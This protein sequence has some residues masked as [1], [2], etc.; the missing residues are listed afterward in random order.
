MRNGR[1]YHSCVEVDGM[2]YAPGGHQDGRWS[3]AEK[4][5]LIT[6]EWSDVAR[7][8]IRDVQAVNYKGHLYIVGGWSGKKVPNCASRKIFKLV[9]NTWEE[10]SSSGYDGPRQLSSPIILSKNQVYCD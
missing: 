2:M 1:A 10:V 3:S 6:G 5:D 9:G 8:P 7:M 4:L